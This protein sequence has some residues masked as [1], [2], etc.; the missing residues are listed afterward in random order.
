MNS[1]VLLGIIVIVLILVG[2]FVLLRGFGSQS[3]NTSQTTST[4][5]GSSG[6]PMI[7]QNSSGQANSAS[8]IVQAQNTVTLTANDWSPATLTIKAGQTVTWVNKS[9]QEAT[10]N[11]NPHPIH[12]D[13]PPLNLGSFPDGGT[14]SLTF[15]TAGTYGYHNHLDPSETGMIIVQ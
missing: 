11:S 6:A 3:M 12:T 8:P 10:V 14:L 2:G 7:Q 9:G 4:Q 13:Y 15:P 1:K 5:P